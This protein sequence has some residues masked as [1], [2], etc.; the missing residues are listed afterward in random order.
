MTRHRHDVRR[1]AHS[2]IYC[3]YD[4]DAIDGAGANET[5]GLRF[6]SGNWR[7]SL[8]CLAD[9]LPWVQAALKKHSERITAARPRR[10]CDEA[11]DEQSEQPRRFA[12]R[13][14]I[15]RIMTAS[16]AAFVTRSSRSRA[17]MRSLC[18]FSA[19]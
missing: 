12:R 18:F 9:D 7:L 2:R 10:A 6:L 13:Q 17:V 11:A 3:T 19:A 15:S 1:A 14:G 4:D 16:A 8:P 5:V